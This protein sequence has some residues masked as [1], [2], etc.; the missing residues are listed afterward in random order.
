[1]PSEVRMRQPARIPSAY[2]L[3]GVLAALAWG[4]S[5]LGCGGAAASTSAAA[6]E[7]PTTAPVDSAD[8][9]VADSVVEQHRHHH[10]GI[11]MFV[12]MSLDTLGV[13]PE[14]RAAIEKIQRDL[15]AALAPAQTAEQS[16]LAVLADGVAAGTVDTTKVDEAIARADAALGGV[17]AATADSLNQ[18]H[19]I[20]DSAQ[21][22]ELAQKLQAHWSVWQHANDEDDGQTVQREHGRYLAAVTRELG[23][24]TEQ[25]G[26]VKSTMEANAP[27]KAKR[28]DVSQVEANLTTFENA[29]A[30]DTFD[31]HALNGAEG[32]NAQIASHGIRR[33]ARFYEALA[34]VLTPDQRTQLAAKLRDHATRQEV[35]P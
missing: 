7:A 8:D 27:E 29:F 1:M 10:G 23:L 28:L 14:Q 15:Y 18:L 2:T 31:A 26:R 17:R 16:L 32:T 34:P 9:P 20:L 25:I 13:A 22:A 21:R 11:T 4:G 5:S 12:A 30:S 24:S 6:S 3:L 19:A 35:T 33:M